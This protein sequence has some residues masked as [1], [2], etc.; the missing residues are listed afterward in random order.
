MTRSTD[1]IERRRI[2]ETGVDAVAVDSCRSKDI[3][4]IV[5][6][7]ELKDADLNHAGHRNR[8]RK[9]PAEFQLAELFQSGV[10]PVHVASWAEATPVTP[11]KTMTGI[12]MRAARLSAALASTAVARRR[13]RFGSGS[14]N[15][16]EPF[17]R[18]HGCPW[19]IPLA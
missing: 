8:R 1:D 19:K 17:V 12:A 2:C 13:G 14:P 15:G 16:R 4:G 10:G 6:R 3:E 5:R 11:F 18:R 9:S 7:I